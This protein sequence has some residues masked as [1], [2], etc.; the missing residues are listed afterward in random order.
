MLESQ[1]V[2][3]AIK[4]KRLNYSGHIS[5][6]LFIRDVTKKVRSVKERV[7]LQEAR[8]SKMHTE[9]FTGAINHE[10]RVP[11]AMLLVNVTQ[12]KDLIK[13]FPGLAANLTSELLSLCGQMSS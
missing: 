13:S 7:L 3:F 10:M 2:F 8:T 11:L 1:D 4:V 12:I 6:S 5:T 9:A